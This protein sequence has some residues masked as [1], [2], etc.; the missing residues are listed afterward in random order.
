MYAARSTDVGHVGGISSLF[1]KPEY[2]MFRTCCSIS[3]DPLIFCPA[4]VKA[5]CIDWSRISSG[6]ATPDP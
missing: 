6:L 5:S 2:T 4:P 3:T 1:P